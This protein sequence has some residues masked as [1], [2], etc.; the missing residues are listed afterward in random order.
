MVSRLIVAVFISI[1]LSSCLNHVQ[2]PKAEKGLIDLSHWDFGSNG[3]IKLD[4]EWEF[5]WGAF[6]ND[7]SLHEY[8]KTYIKVPGLWNNHANV[9]KTTTSYGYASY[10]LCVKTDT[11]TNYAIKHINAATASAIYVNG[12]LLYQAGEVGIDGQKSK[13]G[14]RPAIIP[15]KPDKKELEVILHVSNFHHK[16]G[17]QWEPITLGLENEMQKHWNVR[18]FI[19]L[20]S[21]GCILMIGLYYLLL[22]FKFRHDKSFLYFGLF[23]LIISVRLLV[24][25]DFAIYMLGN[26]QWSVLVR[27][28]YLSFY[29]SI[30]LFLLFVRELF[31]IEL[32]RIVFKIIASYSV[33]FS[34]TVILLKPAVFSY[35]MIYFQ[36]LTL[37]ACLYAFV[38]IVRAYKNK[39]EGA[40]HLLIG[41]FVLFVA[42]VNDVLK[43]NEII[44]SV[45]LI[46]VGLT[47]FIFMKASVLAARIKSHF[48]TAN[49]LSKSL[50]VQ[51][52]EYEK[53]NKN[54]E[55]QN[56]LLKQAKEKAEEGDRLKSA[57]L[58]NMS[59]EIRSP[60]NGVLGFVELLSDPSFTNKE[61]EEFVDI[62]KER[63]YHLLEII[64]DIIDISKIETGQI[65]INHEQV[66]VSELL[67]EIHKSHN[68]K[69][70]EVELIV[71][72]KPEDADY[73]LTTDKVKLKQVLD[74]LVSNAIKFTKKGCV[75]VECSSI[76]GFCK[77]SVEDTGIGMTSDELIV[78]FDRFKQANENISTEYGGTGLGLAIAK[79]YVEK[80]GGSIKVESVIQKGTKFTFTHPVNSHSPIN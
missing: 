34:L 77:F 68:L 53:L 43:T 74:N 50:M 54:F 8:S 4:G 29:S 13:P 20:I 42:Y 24:A 7:S 28:S 59:H 44:F 12:Q 11:I 47:V 25:G 76:N 67:N 48:D 72:T 2:A 3:D 15:F 64:N 18:M 31:P 36:V 63:S 71:K 65:Q 38:V 62:I 61:K 49:N 22:A 26:I 70:S 40:L 21:A 60:M 6:I 58:A 79:A 75:V 17:G 80:L 1:T 57:F 69:K 16:K 37:V 51:N 32:N 10:R 55:H 66:S 33:L 73:T 23:A 39:R 46:S 5:Y 30:L 78:V 56:N 45:S 9:E 14:Y 19:S 27:A 52:S 35:G 41:F